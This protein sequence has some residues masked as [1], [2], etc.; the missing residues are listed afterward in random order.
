MRRA[1]DELAEAA[2][3][4]EFRSS[5]ASPRKSFFSLRQKTRLRRSFMVSRNVCIEEVVAMGRKE[6]EDWN[7]YVLSVAFLAMILLLLGGRYRAGCRTCWVVIG[8]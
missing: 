3:M 6:E 7:L 4:V 8:Y 2:N 5:H 1:C